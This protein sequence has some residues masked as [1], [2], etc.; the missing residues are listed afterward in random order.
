MFSEETEDA[1][2][3]SSE[4]A[5]RKCH[6]VHC[7]CRSQDKRYCSRSCKIACDGSES[8]N[9]GHAECKDPDKLGPKG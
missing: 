1:L 8:C 2:G 3:D 5:F 7:H 4:K 6:H 9:C